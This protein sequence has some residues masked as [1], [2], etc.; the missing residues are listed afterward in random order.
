M[1]SKVV[2]AFFQ[3]SS[4]VRHYASATNAVGLWE[5][6]EKVCTRVF[7]KDKPLLELG[8]GAGR[9]AIGLWELGY[10]DIVAIDFAREMVEEARK[11]GTL[12]NYGI[13]FRQGDATALKFEDEQFDGAIFGFN[14]LMQIP[15]RDNRYRAM[16]EAW[17]VIRPG[18]YFVFTSHDRSN[19]KNR[20]YWQQEQ[21]RWN[22]GEQQRELDEYGDI[23]R[24]TPHGKM[25]IHSPELQEIREDLKKAGF[26]LEVEMPRSTLANEPQRV[27]AFSDE[28]RFWIARKKGA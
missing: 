5:S 20:K 25:Y 11:I 2:K 23:Y 7:A 14:G 24:E 9:I 22:Q 26:V 16:C 8:C 4:V 1:E 18:S 28:C 13:D 21:R 6:E 15:R 12:L 10:R 19:P 3:K 17:R 27:R